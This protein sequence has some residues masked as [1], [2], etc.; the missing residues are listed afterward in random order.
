M[1]RSVKIVPF[2]MERWQSTWENTVDFNLSESGGRR[3]PLRELLRDET[4]TQRFLDH[5]LAY[6]QGNGTPELRSR[7]AD[8]YRD[9]TPGHVLVPTGSSE[10]NSLAMWALARKGAEVVVISPDY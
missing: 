7:I 8:L 3:I 9:A 4:A 1:G 5:P 10:G 6:S 2:E